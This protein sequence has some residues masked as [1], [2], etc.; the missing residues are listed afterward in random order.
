[1]SLHDSTFQYLKPSEKQL[2]TMSPLRDDFARFA[3]LLEQCLPDGPDKTHVIRL[4]RDAAMWAHVSI[5]R[6]ADGSPRE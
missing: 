6:H 1:M 5:T 2:D 3:H 4:I